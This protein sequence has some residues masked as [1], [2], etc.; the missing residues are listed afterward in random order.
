MSGRINW[1]LNQL[2]KLIIMLLNWSLEAD[3][4]VLGKCQGNEW[5]GMNG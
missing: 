1:K 3:S 4:E 5:K 2:T